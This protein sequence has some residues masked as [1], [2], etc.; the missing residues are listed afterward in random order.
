MPPI[1][2][3]LGVS[4]ASP[5]LVPTS[6][7]R[8][9]PADAPPTPTMRGIDAILVGVRAKET[10]RRLAVLD[11]RRKDSLLTEAILYARHDVPVRQLTKVRHPGLA[12]AAPPAAMNP[13]QQRPRLRGVIFR[14]VDV[15]RLRRIAIRHVLDV[16]LGDKT[17]GQLRP[18]R[19]GFMREGV[20]RQ[21]DK[22]AAGE[23]E[24]ARRGAHG[25][26]H[27]G[28]DWVAVF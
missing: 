22:Q 25:W 2:G 6:A 23:G 18:Q 17:V 5:P 3:N 9:P 16:I 27:W 19:R 1:L 14:V 13:N 12:P 10:N 4:F 28:K 24:E 7:A 15:E 8:C 20:E 21:Q 26:G 11:L